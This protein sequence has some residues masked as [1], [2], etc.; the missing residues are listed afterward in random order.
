MKRTIATVAAAAALLLGGTA[1][2]TPA[3]AA[4]FYQTTTCYNGTKAQLA[5]KGSGAFVTVFI[6]GRGSS[7]QYIP[8][9]VVSY[10]RSSSSGFAA[11]TANGSYQSASLRCA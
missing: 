5:V 2:A 10:F 11:A 8:S 9:G 3:S 4:S 6:T 7:T 1:L